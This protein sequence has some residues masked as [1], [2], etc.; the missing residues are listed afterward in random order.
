MKGF[1]DVLRE[2]R[3]T[4]N[5]IILFYCIIN[6]ILVFLAIYLILS[7]SNLS[8][9]YAF[10]SVLIYI[11]FY[12]IFQLRKDKIN[13]IE[14]KYDVLNEKLRTARDNI[15]MEN[16]VIYE[17]E[18]EIIKDMKNVRVSS[19]VDIKKISYKVFTIVIIAFLI[20]YFGLLDLNFFNFKLPGK[21]NLNYSYGKAGSGKGD[22]KE[23]NVLVAGAGKDDEIFGNKSIAIIG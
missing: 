18:S 8:P 5:N 3:Y 15:Q 10:P 2:I 6:T 16:P 13:A 23:G 7:L 11:G 22:I 12:L 4:L 17:L 1:T 21:D 20:A 9:L 14:S 19:F